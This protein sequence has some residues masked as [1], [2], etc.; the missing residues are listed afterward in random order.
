MT[1]VFT[2][3]SRHYGDT[4]GMFASLLQ[5][6]TYCQSL[7]SP[8]RFQSR[9]VTWQE[10][11]QAKFD[12]GIYTA[13]PWD[14]PL[15]P[16][17]YVHVSLEDPTQVAF[18]ASPQHGETDRQ[19]RIKPGRY[20][21]RYY[22]ALTPKQVAFY[23]EWFR[24]GDKPV[25]DRGPIQFA[26]TE[27]E[28]LRVYMNG[29]QSC[30][31]HRYSGVEVYAAGDLAVA[32]VEDLSRPVGHTVIS[33]ALC[34]PE[35]KVFGRVYPTPGD[36]WSI[37]QWTNREEAEDVQ[38]DLF[39]R[40]RAMGYKS[41]DEGGNFEGARLIKRKNPYGSFVGPYLDQSYEV[42]DAGEYFVMTLEGG[43]W[44]AKETN[45]TI[46]GG[47]N[48]EDEEEEELWDC[49][50]CGEHYSYG[51]DSYTVFGQYSNTWCGPVNSQQFCRHCYDES[52]F[53]CDA[54]LVR[55]PEGGDVVLSD[56]RTVHQAWATHYQWVHQCPTTAQLFRPETFII[57]EEGN[58][59]LRT[60]PAP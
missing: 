1:D 33:R 5:A 8:W 34:W 53:F 43:H 7:P 51:V 12:L 3:E 60:D 21:Q 19:T 2:V 41:H 46:D 38:Q 58:Y 49:A 31:K 48:D 22:P 27:E 20:L 13:P 39:N 18:T 29:P 59:V 14:F 25:E 24:K 42:N 45:G 56:G 55:Y 16:E 57:N 37:D 40:L 11:E 47:D 32:Y 54:T 6:D 23:A 52:T 50:N 9:R 17:H 4:F 44:S 15:L 36:N 28:I 26:A 10:R 30:M 35:K